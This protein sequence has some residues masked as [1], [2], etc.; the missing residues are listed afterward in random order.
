MRWIYFLCITASLQSLTFAADKT[1]YILED[2]QRKQWCGFA[3]ESQAKSKGII[4]PSMAAEVSYHEARISSLRLFESD[5]TGDWGVSD[6][7]TFDATERLQTLTRV[8]GFIGE[9]I[10]EEQVFTILNGQSKL[11]RSTSHELRSGEPTEKRVG[12]FKASPIFTTL[13][14]FPFSA[15]LEKRQLIWSSGETCVAG[16]PGTVH[17]NTNS[18]KAALLPK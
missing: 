1:L 5:E 11:Q 3:T 9:D 17:S 12:W 15:L 16:K 4:N 6:A 7:Y 10:K 14:A 2:P 18:R 13:Q 8:I